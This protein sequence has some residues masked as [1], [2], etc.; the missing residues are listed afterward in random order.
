MS[1][2][3]LT[4]HTWQSCA[5]WR[6]HP[7]N[8]NTRQSPS[9]PGLGLWQQCLVV[10][11]LWAVFP[12]GCSWEVC[13]APLLLVRLGLR[14]VS[15]TC[16]TASTSCTHWH[17][18]STTGHPSQSPHSTHIFLLFLIKPN[19]CLS[20]N[21]MST[22]EASIVFLLQHL[23]SV[24][25]I[26]HPLTLSFSYLLIHF[27][28]DPLP[29]TLSL[30]PPLVLAYCSLPCLSVLLPVCQPC[31][32]S[33]VFVSGLGSYWQDIDEMFSAHVLMVKTPLK[34][35]LFIGLCL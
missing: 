30:N 5:S 14:W 31:H 20:P 12:T 10:L 19:I 11:Y 18:R 22:A 2:L 13:T 17:G 29:S 34:F 32:L 33:Q 27:I 8:T 9:W 16:T 25:S 28:W 1:T 15:V 21:A 26:T 35:E 3:T 24:Y 23:L 7:S 6:R 4:R